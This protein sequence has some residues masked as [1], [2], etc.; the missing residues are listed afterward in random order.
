MKIL[1]F[2]D[3]Q[4]LCSATENNDQPVKL[5][6]CIFQQPNLLGLYVLQEVQIR[7]PLLILGNRTKVFRIILDPQDRERWERWADEVTFGCLPTHFDLVAVN[8]KRRLGEVWL[9]VVN[10]KSE[11]AATRRSDGRRQ[12]C[13]ASLVRH[14]CKG[15]AGSVAEG[16][17]TN[18]ACGLRRQLRV[19]TLKTYRK[20]IIVKRENLI[21][22][23]ISIQDN[24]RRSAIYCFIQY[25]KY[26]IQTD[27]TSTGQGS[28]NLGQTQIF[29]GR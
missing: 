22:C 13:F 8:T 23:L 19:K 14:V 10:T 12:R 4:K 7:R 25:K 18:K 21:S 20:D 6:Q 5:I 26:N 27:G 11:A 15:L 24:I 9:A 28:H 2:Q 3:L 29:R 16:K 1:L 17:S